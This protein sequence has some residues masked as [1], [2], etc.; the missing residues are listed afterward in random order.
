[1]ING[2]LFVTG[3]ECRNFIQSLLGTIHFLIPINQVLLNAQR[4]KK[5]FSRNSWNVLWMWRILLLNVII[6]RKHVKHY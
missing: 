6:G 3:I 5:M 1:M 4:G 2:D